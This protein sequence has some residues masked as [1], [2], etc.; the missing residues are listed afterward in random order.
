MAESLYAIPSA[1][2]ALALLGL[3]AVCIEFGHRLGRSRASVSTAESRGHIN[4]IQSAIIGLLAL[5]LGFTFSLALQRFDSRSE[6]VVDEANAIGTAFL[7]TDLLPPAQRDEARVVIGRYLDARVQEATLPLPDREARAKVNA[8]ATRTQA[9]IWNIA[10]RASQLDANSRA[11]LLFVEA[12]NQMIDSFGKRSAA[13][14]RHVPELVLLL[15]LVTFL[16]A[17]SIVG[18]A[19]GVANHRPSLV[20]YVLVGLMVVLVFIVL[21]LDRP[22]RGV[23]QVSHAS[24]L[25]L[26]S[27]L[28]GGMRSSSSPLSSQDGSLTPLSK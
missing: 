9:N 19:A 8:L 16:L 27:T 6:A 2:I 11:P 7:R 3:M 20:A 23:I 21:D 13:L 18:F 15:L 4:G 17:G 26:Q 28:N 24:L 1:L 25:E 14:S 10:V 5:L 12:V 22:R